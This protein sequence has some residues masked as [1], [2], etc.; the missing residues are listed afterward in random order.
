MPSRNNRVDI[1]NPR[2]AGARVTY[3]PVASPTTTSG[4]L[5][6]HVDPNGGGP[7]PN[8]NSNTGRA[9]SYGDAM[10][11]APDPAASP[12]GSNFSTP[13]DVSAAALR[14]DDGDRPTT[15]G[16]S[17]TT[18]NGV[19]YGDDQTYTPH[20]V[21]GLDTEAGDRWPNPARP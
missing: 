9:P 11:C 8:A 18:P 15:T 17:S 2:T 5:E 13:T 4:T 21:L 16:S 3:K 14:P 10:P 6:A 7:S 20:E 19:K 1:F 12:P